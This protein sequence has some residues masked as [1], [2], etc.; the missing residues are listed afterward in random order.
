M[1][2]KEET[3]IVK[4]C[5]DDIFYK[6]LK[7]YN[8]GKYYKIN[9][10]KFLFKVIR[11]FNLPIIPFVMG[12]WKKDIKKYKLFVFKDNG[13]N[14]QISKYIKRHNKNCKIILYFWNPINEYTKRFLGD[15]NI[16]E[17]WSFDLEDVKKYNLKYNPQYYSKTVKL[18]NKGIKSDFIFLG[19]NKNRKKY[20]ENLDKELKEHNV[21]GTFKII[22][23]EKDLVEYEDYLKLVDESKAIIDIV[24]ENQNGLTLRPMEALFF[25]KKLI[26]NNLDIVNYDFYNPN[27]IFVLGKDD[28]NNIKQ[29][30]DSPYEPVN[31]EIVNYYDFEEWIKRFNME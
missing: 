10:N 9:T 6:Y 24:S 31:E 5:N 19:R 30:I 20:I 18:P 3:L 23:S 13:Y 14:M 7:N 28:M 12:E 4:I 26:T 1:I 27:N 21:N 15:K 11:K 25:N 17:I 16:D 8:V 2:N 29:F 22:E